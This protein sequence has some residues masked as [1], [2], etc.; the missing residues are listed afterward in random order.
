MKTTRYSISIR[1]DN[2]Q[3]IDMMNSLK[4]RCNKKGVSFSFAVVEAVKCI[5]E[6][7]L[8]NSE[9]FRCDSDITGV[10]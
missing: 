8:N 3:M 7:K 9:V 10:K 2:E 6:G 5:V 1:Q 4:D